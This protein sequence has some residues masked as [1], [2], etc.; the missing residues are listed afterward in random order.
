[1]SEITSLPVLGIGTI[2][3]KCGGSQFS[4]S[5]PD[6]RPDN[7]PPNVL[8]WSDCRSCQ[9]DFLVKLSPELENAVRGVMTFRIGTSQQLF[10][11]LFP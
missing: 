3:P 11:V 6:I 2:C 10:K 9:Q 7:W 4:I 1:M 5:V 8:G